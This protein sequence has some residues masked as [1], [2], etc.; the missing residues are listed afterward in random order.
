MPKTIGMP[1]SNITYSQLPSFTFHMRPATPTIK[2]PMFAAV[3]IIPASSGRET[4]D[5]TSLISATPLGHV[6]PTPIQTMKRTTKS[7]SDDCTK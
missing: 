2:I 3:P 7:C 6:P 5:Q 1:P 4:P